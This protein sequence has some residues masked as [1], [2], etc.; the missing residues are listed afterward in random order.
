VSTAKQALAFLLVAG[1]ASVI[2]AYGSFLFFGLE[3]GFRDLDLM[4]WLY[5]PV[6]QVPIWAGFLVV[7]GLMFGL[8][9]LLM[10]RMKN[11]ASHRSWLVSAGI[12]VGAGASAVLLAT[13]LGLAVIPIA[14]SLGAA[15]GGLSALLWFELVE[16][17]IAH[18]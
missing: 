11:L 10:L 12:V 8:P 2:L 16:R 13:W 6:I 7:G 9:T 3:D 14:L 18:D 15:G 17:R 5:G 1:I 4:E